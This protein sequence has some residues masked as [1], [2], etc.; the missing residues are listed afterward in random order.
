MLNIIIG[1]TANFMSC[2][3]PSMPNFLHDEDAEEEEESRVGIVE[4]SVDTRTGEVTG[5]DFRR[6]PGHRVNGQKQPSWREGKG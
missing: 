2:L 6:S 3:A 5:G 4:L 1:I